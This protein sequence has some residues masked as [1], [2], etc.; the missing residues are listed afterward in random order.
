MYVYKVFI[1]VCARVHSVT[2]FF[3]ALEWVRIN[4]DNCVCIFLFPKAMQSENVLGS[5][6]AA[7]SHD[8][9]PQFMLRTGQKRIKG[10]RTDPG[11]QMMTAGP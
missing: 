8:Q 6:A 4:P 9:L 5:E 7:A 1:N 2:P 10:D 3:V 11:K